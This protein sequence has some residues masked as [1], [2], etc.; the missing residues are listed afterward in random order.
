VITRSRL[1]GGATRFGLAGIVAAG[2]M[3]FSFGVGVPSS[4]ASGSY[5]ASEASFCKSLVTWA[6]TNAKYAAP[7]GTG[8]TAYKTWAKKLLPF[9]EQLAAT[10]PNAQT[11]VVLDD[12]VTVLKD[13]YS[14]SSLKKLEAYELANH[15][16]FEADTKSL[17]NSIKG[18]AKYM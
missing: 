4:G 5:S 9:Y 11:K 1:L 10:A 14:S 18:C 3:V 12:V 2:I 15:A 8:L 6:E 7:A 16:K 13:Y 17:A